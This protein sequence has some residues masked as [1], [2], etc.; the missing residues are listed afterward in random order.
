M[1]DPD[2]VA[3]LYGIQQ[4]EKDTLDQGV[5]P[6]VVALVR[7]ARKQI[8]FG[9]KLHDDVGT[10]Q[11]IHNPDQRNDIRVLAGQV[12][13]ANLALLVLELAGI[14]AGFVEGLDSI[15]DVGVDV[16]SSIDDTVGADAKDACE[17]QPVGQDES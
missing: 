6:D 13:Q 11:G 12:V 4:L 5:I 3:E 2:G 15:G 9:A 1:V 8:S 17:F 14:Q 7:D 10:V 16:H